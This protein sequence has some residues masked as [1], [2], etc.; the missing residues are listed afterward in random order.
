MCS[1]TN[2]NYNKIPEFCEESIKLGAKYVKFNNMLLQGNA[3]KIDES[4][5]L[6]QSQIN[7]FFDLVEDC[8]SKYDKSVLTVCRCGSFGVNRKKPHKFNCPAGVDMIC[9]TP[10]K[11]AYPCVFLS[12]PGYEIGYYENGKVYV[13]EKFVNNQKNC[14]ALKKLNSIG[15]ENL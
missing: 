2:K 8:R 1:I 13:D 4:L 14:L 11:K 7:E 15:E 5:I 12:K 10:D 3:T 6:N 9:I